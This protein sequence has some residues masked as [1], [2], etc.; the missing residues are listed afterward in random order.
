MLLYRV[1]RHAIFFCCNDLHILVAVDYSA[2][3]NALAFTV[4]QCFAVL[5][6]SVVFFGVVTATLPGLAL[7]QIYHWLLLNSNR[8]ILNCSF[9]SCTRQKMNSTCIMAL[10]L[11]WRGLNISFCFFYDWLLE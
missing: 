1:M 2:K 4:S 6:S 8:N 3:K 5:V 7:S 11:D 10:H 9:N